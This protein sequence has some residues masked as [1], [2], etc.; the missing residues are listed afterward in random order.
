MTGGTIVQA[1]LRDNNIVHL[2]HIMVIEKRHMLHILMLTLAMVSSSN[3]FGFR[4]GMAE[5]SS[6]SDSYDGGGS[7]GNG[8][9]QSD[10]GFS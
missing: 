9:Y 4:G 2:R 7:G 1:L 10:F 8:Y 3:P 6:S 5:E